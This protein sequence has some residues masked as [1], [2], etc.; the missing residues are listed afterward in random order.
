MTNPL[1]Q[2][3]GLPAFDVIQPEHIA[4]AIAALLAADDAALER[5]VGDEVPADYDAMS[6]VLDT[7]GENLRYI[8]SVIGHLNGVADTPA[9]RAA[10][11]A[12]LPIVTEHASRHASDE[13]LY[14]KYKAI[15]LAATAPGRQLS[16]AR[17]QALG[18]AIRDFVR[19]M[20]R[21][22]RRC[23]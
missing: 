1:L 19:A 4:P 3:D 11:T 22:R 6:T 7:A 10:Y 20:R 17:Q 14:A 8:W 23:H 2:F 9:L 15:A 12:A 13:R 21:H 18:N 16:A 5:A